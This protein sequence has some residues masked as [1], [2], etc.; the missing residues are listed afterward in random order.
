MRISVPQHAA[1]PSTSVRLDP[2]ARPTSWIANAIAPALMV[3]GITIA[4]VAATLIGDDAEGLAAFGV[5]AGAGLWFGGSIAL[6]L[7]RATVGRAL[8]ILLAAAA[9]IVLVV[10]ALTLGWTGAALDLAMEFG[11][12][13][14]AVVVVDVIVLG[15]FQPRLDALGQSASGT[16]LTAE[17]SRAWPL[18]RL[19]VDRL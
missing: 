6:S 17:L 2:L 12:G 16:S 7:R 15:A 8:I 1:L 19:R 18:V 3:A 11:V 13:A 4:V 10:L 14:L 5:E 9:G